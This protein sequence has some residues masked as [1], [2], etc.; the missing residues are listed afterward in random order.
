MNEKK[1]SVT[2]RGFIRKTART[3]SFFI[4]GGLAG[5][6]LA[7]SK[8][9]EWVWQI[10]PTKCIQCGN[11]ATHCVLTPSASKCV[12]EYSMCGYCRIC[13]G[14]NPP[15]A[16]AFDEGAE[17]QI[18]PTGAITRKYVEEPY[19]EYTIDRELCIGCARCV[20][21]CAAY[22]NG[23]LYMQIQRDLCV[24]CNECAIAVA[25][26]GKAISRI[27]AQQQYLSKRKLTG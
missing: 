22:G 21:G 13:S 1:E 17:N 25:C 11:C 20:K 27:P 16:S 9:E 4:L 14:F 2:R 7:N 23:S 12:H 18:C 5:K 24:N 6:V 8:K 26:E 19:Y 15:D 10:D 3:I